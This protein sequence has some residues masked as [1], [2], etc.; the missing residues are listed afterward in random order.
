MAKHFWDFWLL[1]L[2][3]YLL[4]KINMLYQIRSQPEIAFHFSS[5]NSQ[6]NN[7]GQLCACSFLPKLVFVNPCIPAWNSVSQFNKNTHPIAWAVPSKNWNILLW[8]IFLCMLSIQADVN[9][10]PEPSN[11]LKRKWKMVKSY[12]GG[13]PPPR[14]L[15]RPTRTPCATAPTLVT[16]SCHRPRPRSVKGTSYGWIACL[17]NKW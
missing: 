14:P 12:R 9:C 3:S 7:Q 1:S 6:K 5:S 10:S 15:R 11:N 2:Q 4:K 8:D 17:S 16:C 13:R